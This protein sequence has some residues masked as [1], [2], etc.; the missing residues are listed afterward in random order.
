[1]CPKLWSVTLDGADNTVFV[2]AL[3]CELS[4]CKNDERERGGD[5]RR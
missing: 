1:M 4:I 3:R 5:I 2:F